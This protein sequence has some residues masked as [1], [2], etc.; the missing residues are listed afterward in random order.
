M[1]AILVVDEAVEESYR[2]GRLGQPGDRGEEDEEE[3]ELEGNRESPHEPAREEGEAVGHPVR[4]R[5]AANVT[6]HLHHD[7]LA[8]HIDFGRLGLPYWR[9]CRVQPVAYARNDSRDRHL[10]DAEGRGLENS[11][12][13]IRQLWHVSSLGAACFA[14]HQWSLEPSL[15]RLSSS[16]QI[17]PHTTRPRARPRKTQCRRWRSRCSRW[18][19]SQRNPWC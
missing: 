9:C 16:F 13:V 17:S 15:S 11:S 8:A 7:E 2:P 12:F 14:A 1:D 4:Q 3:H 6:D 19:T 10:R 18:W 5:E